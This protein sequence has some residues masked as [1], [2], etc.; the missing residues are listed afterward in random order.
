MARVIAADV[1]SI[2]SGMRVEL[3]PMPDAAR[4]PL[5]TFKPAA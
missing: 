5:P 2:K 3:V 4:Y 1:T